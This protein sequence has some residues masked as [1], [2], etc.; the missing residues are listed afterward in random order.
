MARCWWKRRRWRAWSN[1][2]KDIAVVTCIEQAEEDL[3]CPNIDGHEHAHSQARQRWFSTASETNLH[4]QPCERRNFAGLTTQFFFFGLYTLAGL[5]A[6]RIV[7]CSQYKIKQAPVYP[8]V[9]VQI[10]SVTLTQ[11]DLFV[12]KAPFSG[13]VTFVLALCNYVLVSVT[14]VCS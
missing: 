8:I 12:N 2:D 11:V 14:L 10:R 13:S 5:P 3:H 6:E 7:L 4:K 9:L 1:R